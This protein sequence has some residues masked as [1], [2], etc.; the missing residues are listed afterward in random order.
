MINVAK[1]QKN[2]KIEMK[3]KIWNKIAV[4]RFLKFG[5]YAA[6]LVKN[7]TLAL[8]YATWITAGMVI[9]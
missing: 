9:L 7:F 2:L 4:T 5:L 8:I 1:L 6:L 3:I